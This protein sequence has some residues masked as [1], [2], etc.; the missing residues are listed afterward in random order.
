MHAISRRLRVL[1]VVGAALALVVGCGGSPGTDTTGAAAGQD[2]P[3][4]ELIAAAKKEGQLTFYTTATAGPAQKQADAFTAK[5]GI[6]TNMVR[7][8][9]AQM[10]SRFQAE[11]NSSG[12]TKADIIFTTNPV[13]IKDAVQK[14]VLVALQEAGIPNFPGDFPQRFLLPDAGSAVT[15]VQPVGIAYNTELVKGD[16]IPKGWQDLLNPKWKGKIAVATPTSALGYVGEWVVIGKQE[17][18]DYLAKLGTQELKVYSAG[19]T[20]AAA[21]GAGEVSLA[22]AML[23]SN[24][25]PDKKKGAP[26]D[27]FVPENTSGIELSVGIVAKA[28]HPNAARLFAMFSMSEEGAKILADATDSVSPYDTANLPKQ[29]EAADIAGAPAKLAEIQRL[30]QVK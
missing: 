3:T 28:Q 6:P 22:G 23:V 10:D 17:G 14:K 5:Y 21:L 8:T 30:L 29:Y 4:A 26:V 19:S 2:G 15:L 1:G 25:V 20:V 12:G 7:L 24:T 16:D 9:G 18:G 27:I 13:L 11:I